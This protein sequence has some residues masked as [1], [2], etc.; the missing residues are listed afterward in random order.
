MTARAAPSPVNVTLNGKPVVVPAGTRL[1]DAARE[2]GIDIPN[3]CY[4]PHLSVAG[5]CRMCA[6]EIEGQRGLPISCNTVCAEGMKVQTESERVKASRRAVMEF[7]LVNHP[8]DCPICDQAGECKLQVYY[9]QHDLRPSRLDVEKVRYGK[10]IQVGPRVVLDQERCV[11]CTRCIRFCDEVTGTGEL[12]MLNR[13]DHNV[14]ATFPGA[15]LDNDYSV[16]TA[17]I[18][19]VGALTQSDFRFKA[20]VWFLKPNPTIC[21]GCSKG[22]NVFVDTYDHVIVAHDNGT[23]HRVRARV[24]D[25][26]NEAWM[27]DFGRLEYKPVNDAR[28][29]GARLHGAPRPIDE[30]ARDAASALG[31][32]GRQAVVLTSFDASLEEMEALRQV[33]HAALGGAAVAAVPVRGDGF[34]DDFLIRADKHPN[35][36]G[37]EWLGLARTASELP[38]L[39]AKAGAVLVHRADLFALD[40]RGAARSAFSAVPVRVVIAANASETADLATHLLPGASF[41]EREG[42]WVNEDG[43]IQRFKRA[44]RPREGTRDDLALIAALAQGRVPDRAPA[45]FDRLGAVHRRF[46]GIAWGDVGDAGVVPV[47]DAKGVAV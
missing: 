28:V 20:R 40:D 43:R 27:C 4:H 19:P 44:Y 18:C 34:A 26:V 45:I 25:D 5:N 1:I 17:E 12:R 46:A 36:K 3:F 33:A 22:C 38:A 9:M 41:I 31:R 14:I 35:R 42:S 47:P 10:R 13:G 16:C 24:N 23:A 11:E 8:I 15:S 2:A 32:A 37:A 7:L 39:L 29:V 6:V 21:P 30:V